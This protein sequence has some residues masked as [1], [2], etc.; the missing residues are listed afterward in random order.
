MVSINK[1][2]LRNCQIFFA[3]MD[4]NSSP[5]PQ[6]VQL[7]LT[8]P[9]PQGGVI[10]ILWAKSDIIKALQARVLE[11]DNTIGKIK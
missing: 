4:K 6:S 1:L 9:W 2:I 8:F 5:T 10:F 7:T 11:G 3:L